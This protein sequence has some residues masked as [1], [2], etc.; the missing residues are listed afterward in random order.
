MKSRF[1]PE[2]MSPT[3]HAPSIIKKGQRIGLLLV[4]LIFV[5]L[6]FSSTL[7]GAPPQTGLTP[8]VIHLLGKAKKAAAS[9]DIQ[10]ARK[11]WLLAQ[12]T[13]PSLPKPPWVDNPTL[14][15]PRPSPSPVPLPPPEPQASVHDHL[16]T[17]LKYLALAGILAAFVW[18]SAALYRDY[19]KKDE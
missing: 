1:V 17:L 18:Q 12:S 10:N 5:I 2:K 3:I 16:L 19:R 6:A 7:L 14:V 8:R 15:A 4:F 13:D 11:Y 9:G